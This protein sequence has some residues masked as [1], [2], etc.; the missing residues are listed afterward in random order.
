[1]KP[2]PFTRPPLEEPDYLRVLT[3]VRS[4]LDAWDRSNPVGSA[5]PTFERAWKQACRDRGQLGSPKQREAIWQSWLAAGKPLTASRREA[6]LARLTPAA[7]AWLSCVPVVT[8]PDREP[9][10]D[11][12]EVPAWID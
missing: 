11:D 5:R 4:A 6:I 10:E 2:K 8:A 9:G 3:Q 1:M 12:D 7:R